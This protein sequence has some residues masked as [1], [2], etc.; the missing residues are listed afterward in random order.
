[1]SDKT[2]T[3]I[4][5]LLVDHL[6]LT[7]IIKTVN[8]FPRRHLVGCLASYGMQDTTCKMADWTTNGTSLGRM[9]LIW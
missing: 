5:I 4:L 6:V 1:M 7:T 9:D 2:H 3:D 8:F